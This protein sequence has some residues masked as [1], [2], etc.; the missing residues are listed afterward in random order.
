MKPHAKKIII[1]LDAQRKEFSS[2]FS[3]IYDKTKHLQNLIETKTKIVPA[4]KKLGKEGDVKVITLDSATEEML[5]KEGIPLKEEGGQLKKDDSRLKENGVSIISRKDITANM[6]NLEVGKRTREFV[7]R[8]GALFAEHSKETVHAGINLFEVNEYEIWRSFFS[9]ALYCIEA[10]LEIIEKERPDCVLI[11]DRNDVYQL[12]FAEAAKS[13]NIEVI[14]RT[15]VLPS[16]SG[17]LEQFFIK[18][19][20]WSNVPSSLRTLH[21]N[22]TKA[23][24]EKP[25]ILITHDNIGPNKIIPWAKEI[26]SDVFDVLFVGVKENSA[27]EK[28]KILFSLLNQ[29]STSNIRSLMRKKK[30]GLKNA[31]SELGQNQGFKEK[32]EYLG[33]PLWSLSKPLLTFLCHSRFFY[34]AVMIEFMKEM[35]KREQP[36]AVISVDDLS[37]YGRALLLLCQQEKV[38]SILVEHGLIIKENI[39]RPSIATKMLVYG[40]QTVDALVAAGVKKENIEITGQCEGKL[41]EDRAQDRKYICKELGLSADK[42][43]IV[44]TSQNYNKSFDAELHN[45]VYSA[46]PSFPGAQFI[47]KLHP[48]EEPEGHE[49]RIKNSGLANARITKDLN[50]QRIINGCDFLINGL[51]TVGIEALRIGTRVISVNPADIPAVYYPIEKPGISE[52]V[53]TSQ[54]LCGAIGRFLSSREKFEDETIALGK[55]YISELGEKASKKTAEEIEKVIAENKTSR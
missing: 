53:R 40:K 21:P 10:A 50:L 2:F 14:D 33:V 25:L 5:K 15:G 24:K 38:P 35:L 48:D 1:P 30:F 47:I 31:L 22:S 34:T 20:G 42:P 16:I 52:T 36:C 8:L 26:N 7:K 23:K 28:E 51:S 9:R 54:E 6:L 19:L 4:I 39:F 18:A 32:F 46:I 27:Y 3:G 44:F 29:Y 55:Y 13:R 17:S 43:V 37:R 45:R 41:S 12:A 11:F 49:S